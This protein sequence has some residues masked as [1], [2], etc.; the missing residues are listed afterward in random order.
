[1]LVAVNVAVGVQV[2]VAVLVRDAVWVALA[3]CVTLGVYVIVRVGEGVHVYVRVLVADGV[4]VLD[5][6]GD[7]LADTA[8]SSNPARF[9]TSP[10]VVMF[11]VPSVTVTV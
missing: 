2:L 1:M 3:V 7:A 5:G 4:N 10:L 8:D 11:N 9:A 6:V